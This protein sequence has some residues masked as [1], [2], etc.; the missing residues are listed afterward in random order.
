VETAVKACAVLAAVGLFA[1][2]TPSLDQSREPVDR[3]SFG[4]TVLTL[5]CKRIAYL[6]SVDA[7][8][9]GDSPHVDV[10]GDQYRQIC[11]DGGPMP[12]DAPPR[13]KALL[14]QRDRLIQAVDTIVPEESLDEVQALLTADGFL[15]TT[16]N[17]TTLAAVDGLADLLLILADDPELAPALERLNHRLGYQPAT[18]ALGVLP[19][20]AGYPNLDDVVRTFSAAVT[21]GGVLQLEFDR[22]SAAL[23]FALRGTEP[24][25]DWAD[26]ERTAA[27]AVDFAFSRHDRLEAGTPIPMVRRDRRGL[28]A[29]AMAAEGLPPQ[30]VDNDGDG[31]ADADDL[32]RFIDR[33]GTAFVAPAPFALADQDIDDDWPYRDGAGRALV[34]EGGSALYQYVDLDGSVLAALARDAAALFNP[35]TGPAINLLQGLGPIAGER[36]AARRDGNG[37]AFEYRG[38]DGRASPLLDL[39][40]SHLLLLTDSNVYDLIAYVRQLLVDHEARAAELLEAIFEAADIARKF[41]HAGLEP[42][43][44]L[45]DDL[46]PVIVDIL[47]VPGL[48]EDLVGLMQTSTSDTDPTPLLASIGQRIAEQMQYKDV[49][50]YNGQQQ[51]VGR[52]RTRVAR[53]QPDTDMNRSVLQRL[54]HLIA[55]TDG[56][57]LCNKSGARIS[58][59]AGVG[60]T[61][62]TYDRCKLFDIPNLAVFYL[63]SMAWKRHGDG[64]YAVGKPKAEFPFTFGRARQ[65]GVLAGPISGLLGQLVGGVEGA[66]SGLL[67]QQTGIDGMGVHPTPEALNRSIYLNPMP[68]FLADVLDPPVDRDGEPIRDAHPGAL[69]AWE[70]NGFYRQVRPLVQAFADHDAEELLVK[71][72]VVFH[73][74]Y[75][76]R[77]S[78]NHQNTD[79]NGPD[80]AFASNVVSYEPALIKIFERGALVKAIVKHVPAMTSF[81]VND[82]RALDVLLDVARFVLRADPELR[83]RDGSATAYTNDGRLVEPLSRWHILADAHRRKRVALDA[84]S[85]IGRRWR[86]GISGLVDVLLRGEKAE[87]G[88][89]R[90]QNPRVRGVAL[91]SLDFVEARLRSHDAAGDRH[92]WLTRDLVSRAEER[93]TG[94]VF[95]AV[96][97]FGTALGAAAEVRSE[98]EQMLAHV[99]DDRIDPQGFAAALTSSADLLQ[100]VLDDRDLVPI[101]H[102]AGAALDPE[103]N[104]IKS[105]LTLLREASRADPKGTLAAI[106]KNALKEHRPGHTALADLLDG[107]TEIHRA[108]PFADGGKRYRA[109]DYR[110]AMRRIAEFLGEKRRGLHK[111][112]EIIQGR[113]L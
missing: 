29:V 30:F 47:N 31:L 99:F 38:V 90:F 98:L 27:L 21:T 49:F 2:C 70:L 69:I 77:Q 80:Y 44:P 4:T 97:D 71:L 89:W 15:A 104:V 9:T 18:T 94:P 73:R 1:A 78:G 39:V 102:A 76:S 65:F 107:L 11:R 10:A 19:V 61:V 64:R 88:T 56:V 92:T 28:A 55:S 95:A 84:I 53:S 91:A 26:P 100:F 14:A 3:G 54:L 62:L 83:M 93:I 68:R 108:R 58:D 105:Q 51:V 79:P 25:P 52:F 20:V 7:H 106:L 109:E 41:T 35:K 111:F 72:L 37:E 57:R 66:I 45:F 87:D 81:Q 101:A 33:E 48:A 6:E 13:I 67:A 16:D 86:T 82:R 8:E 85:G 46:V 24:A 59:P 5:A 110:S 23:G 96:A 74:H 43:S 113:T 42:G 17:G 75:P 32:G 103:R 22:L 40:Y 50:G 112:I 60:V 36:T 63:Q 34:N 12:D